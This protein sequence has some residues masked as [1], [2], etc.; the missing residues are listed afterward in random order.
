MYKKGYTK[1]PLVV[2]INAPE[3]KPIVKNDQIVPANIVDIHFVCDHRFM[4][5]GRTVVMQQAVNFLKRVY[6]ILLSLWMSFKI[7]KDILK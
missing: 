3:I 2:T 5:A 7:Q 1:I 4:D 6:Y